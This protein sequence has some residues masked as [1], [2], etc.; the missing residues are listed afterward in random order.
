MARGRACQW[1]QPRATI[2]SSGYARRSRSGASSD[3]GSRPGA[4]T[5][6]LNRSSLL[7][8][9]AAV[10]VFGPLLACGVLE[11]FETCGLLTSGR[12]ATR[13]AVPSPT[14]VGEPPTPRAPPGEVWVGV[15]RE[16]ADADR[17]GSETKR[18]SST[19]A[20]RGSGDGWQALAAWRAWWRRGRAI[21][22]SSG[23]SSSV[24]A[25]ART[26]VTDD[27]E[28]HDGG[29]EA[30]LRDFGACGRTQRRA[31]GDL[32]RCP[33]PRASEWFDR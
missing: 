33:C 3:P 7:F 9:G 31:L 30:G 15:D 20:G 12:G 2:K 26:L 16:V 28:S 10:L 6:S 1:A 18:R 27:L 14:F 5:I 21:R 4:S 24:G 17:R 32:P 25:E 23:G 19:G 11:I 29:R 22:S 13:G 8:G